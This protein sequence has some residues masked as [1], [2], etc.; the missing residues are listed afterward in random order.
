MRDLHRTTKWKRKKMTPEHRRALDFALTLRE[1][2]QNAPDSMTK[3]QLEK[4][5]LSIRLRYAKTTQEK[6]DA[7]LKAIRV[8]GARSLSEIAEDCGLSVEQTFSLIKNLVAKGKIR[9]QRVTGISNR[10]KRKYPNCYY[11]GV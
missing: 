2:S 3:H 4:T 6:N 9:E 7:I 10:G 11:F 5:I 8:R 1:L